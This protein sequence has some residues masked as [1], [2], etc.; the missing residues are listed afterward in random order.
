[1]SWVFWFVSL[2]GVGGAIAFIVLAPAIAVPLL[3]SVFNVLIK[4]RPCLV[5][6]AIVTAAIAGNIHGHT[7]EAAK[8]RAAE[9]DAQ[10]RNQRVDLDNAR[11]SAADEARRATIIQETSDVQRRKDADYIATLEGR[12]A[13]AL[14]DSDLGGVR[15]QSRPGRAKPAA[16]AR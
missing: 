5:A 13:C 10:L 3:T 8:C 15:K 6:I 16:G 9:L 12:P 2:V 4:C 11:R 7:K 14:D 1:M